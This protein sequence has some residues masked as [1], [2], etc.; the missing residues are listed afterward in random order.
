MMAALALNV[1][2]LIFNSDECIR[3]WIKIN[4]LN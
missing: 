1:L 4:N 3:Q 2:K